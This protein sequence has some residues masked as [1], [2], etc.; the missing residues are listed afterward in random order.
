M[1][2][3]DGTE[4]ESPSTRRRAPNS[5]VDAAVEADPVRAAEALRAGTGVGGAAGARGRLLRR[6]RRAGAA[7]LPADEPL[8]ARPLHC[9]GGG[10]EAGR[11]RAVRTRRGGPREA[12]PRRRRRRHLPLPRHPRPA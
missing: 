12:R 1:R 4:L 11:R 7:P 2:A 9:R 6:V 3:A 10:G 5:G 8:P